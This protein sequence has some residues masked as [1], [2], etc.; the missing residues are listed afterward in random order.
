MKKTIEL[1]DVCYPDYF[2]GYHR[3]VLA[4]PVYNNMTFTELADSIQEEMNYNWD[5]L[6]NGSNGYTKTE[7]LIIDEYVNKLRTD[8]V[9]KDSALFIGEELEYNEQGE[10]SIYAYFALCRL[11]TKYGATF[12]DL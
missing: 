5:Y 2:T 7:F 10:D 8:P 9:Y 3:P 12:L 11:N 4:I 6:T 1:L